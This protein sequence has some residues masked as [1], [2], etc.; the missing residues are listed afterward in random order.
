MNN[1]ELRKQIIERINKINEHIY[2]EKINK[3]LKEQED[4]KKKGR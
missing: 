4:G 1:E 3:L 2:L